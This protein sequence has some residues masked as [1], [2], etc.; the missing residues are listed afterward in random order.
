MDQG[1]FYLIGEAEV[2]AKKDS[3][4]LKKILI[5]YAYTFLRKNFRHGG[6]VLVI[7][8]TRLLKVGMTYEIWV[9]HTELTIH[10]IYVLLWVMYI[11][12][13]LLYFFYLCIHI[14]F[15][16]QFKSVSFLFLIFFIVLASQMLL[17]ITERYICHSHIFLPS[18]TDCKS[19][20]ALNFLCIPLFSSY[21]RPC[22]AC[23]LPC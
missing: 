19:W 23:S 14:Y 5:N 8:Q 2:V 6:K 20:Q 18:L 12:S 21:L 1:V 17:S 10:Y 16:V 4:L 15:L 9:F 22:F 3:S 13:I 7:P 11:T